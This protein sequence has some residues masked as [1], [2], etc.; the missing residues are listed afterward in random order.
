VSKDVLTRG[1]FSK[2]KGVHR[3][4]SVGNIGLEVKNVEKK[5]YISARQKE[6]LSIS[7]LKSTD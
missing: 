5:L 3:Q 6:L 7:R 2:P 4:K 1:Y